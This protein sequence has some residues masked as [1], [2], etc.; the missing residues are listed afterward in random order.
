MVNWKSYILIILVSLVILGTNIMATPIR[1]DVKHA[2]TFI[3][4]KNDS[5]RIIPNGTGFFVGLK[6]ETDPNF[7]NTYL[8]TAKHVLLKKERDTFVDSI[9]IRLNKK[10]GD[11]QLFEIPLSG[12]NAIEV[13]RHED[14][15]VDVSL[16]PMFPDPNVFE[17]KCIPETLI[18]T[19]ENFKKLK[20]R[21]GDEVF[22]VGLFTQYFGEQKNYPIVRF[23]RVALI[24]DER[25]PW[26][27]KRDQPP[28]MLDLY[29]V[30]TQSFGGNSGSPVFFW[31]NPTRDSNTL[32]IAPPILLL[33]GIM[34]GSFLNP[35]EIQV[36]ETSKIPISL[37]NVGIAA[38]IP[39]Y[40]LHE[41]LF[42][43]KLKKLRSY[44]KNQAI[45]KEEN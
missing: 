23:G 3:F 24:T 10:T 45:K 44:G 26:K 34:K 18:T 43:S 25:I 4:V 41:V 11:S 38:I 20:I 1:D 14:A 30:E 13:F 31:L 27:D 29:L 7:V 17:F 5:G 6:N 40:R 16:I 12:P 33:A 2:V 21:E 39:A 15:D 9:F 32:A 36:V 19:K 37:E 22:F 42:S 8:I 35:K 28:K